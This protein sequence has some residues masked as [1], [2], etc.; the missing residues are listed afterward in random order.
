M[1]TV[2]RIYNDLVEEPL[3]IHT[4]F[5]WWRW[6]DLFADT[7]SD[8]TNYTTAD[9]SPDAGTE[10]SRSRSKL[11]IDRLK[12]DIEA[13]IVDYQGYLV[14]E[15]LWRHKAQM[16]HDLEIQELAKV[17]AHLSQ[18]ASPPMYKVKESWRIR[19]GGSRDY[20]GPPAPNILLDINLIWI[21]AGLFTPFPADAAHFLCGNFDLYHCSISLQVKSDLNY[22]CIEHDGA[23]A[24]LDNL[25]LRLRD[26]A[27]PTVQLSRGRFVT[28]AC[29]IHTQMCRILKYVQRGF[30]WQPNLW[31][32]QRRCLR[33]QPLQYILALQPASVKISAQ[34]V[35]DTNDDET[36][37]TRTGSD[38][39][40]EV[41][42]RSERVLFSQNLYA[43]YD[44]WLAFDGGSP[45]EEDP[46]RACVRAFNSASGV[47]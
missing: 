34:D 36:V 46:L 44:Y 26:T 2:R 23:S 22:S 24:A 41:D 14:T 1:H 11:E 15:G 18:R 19:P 45:D 38:L 33:D 16:R 4:S 30:R 47:Q 42:R 25:Q 21:D 32:H 6:Y 9:E 12:A 37:S 43:G 28:P 7:D 40:D 31:T 8:E 3:H 39:R 27:F 17:L 20:L 13:W 10:L 5:R 35:A 29:S